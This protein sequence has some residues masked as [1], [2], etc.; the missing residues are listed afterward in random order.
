MGDRP[1][2]YKDDCLGEFAGNLLDAVALLFPPAL[3]ERIRCHPPV[4][5]QWRVFERITWEGCRGHRFCTE[6]RA[7]DALNNLCDAM[8]QERHKPPGYPG[9]YTENTEAEGLPKVCILPAYFVVWQPGKVEVPNP[10]KPSAA[11]NRGGL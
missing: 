9:F 2:F 7:C 11:A 4:H 5:C 1:V 6:Q 8:Y 3:A 10:A